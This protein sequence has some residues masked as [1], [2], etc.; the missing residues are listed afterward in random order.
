MH[1]PTS[2]QRHMITKLRTS[3]EFVQITEEGT[4][5]YQCTRPNYTLQNLQILLLI[6]EIYHSSPSLIKFKID[7]VHGRFIRSHMYH[8]LAALSTASRE[9]M[10]KQMKLTRHPR[11]IQIQMHL[12]S[13]TVV[14][15]VYR[16][17]LNL[18]KSSVAF[19]GVDVGCA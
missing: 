6:A 13:N 3:K 17:L 12:S 14:V 19:N 11:C 8:W 10:C 4:G 5:K 18:F 16:D 1:M 2:N 7:K 9:P 15:L